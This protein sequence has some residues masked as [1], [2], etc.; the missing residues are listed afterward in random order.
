M[1]I[2]IRITKFN[3]HTLRFRYSKSNVFTNEFCLE[4]YNNNK[5]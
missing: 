1:P 3:F 4:D 5:K 2:K